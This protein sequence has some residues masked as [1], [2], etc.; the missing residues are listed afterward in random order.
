MRSR[1]IAGVNGGNRLA[2]ECQRQAFGL[3]TAGVVE[4]DVQVPLNAGVHIPHRLAMADRQNAG[5]LRAAQRG[6]SMFTRRG[7]AGGTGKPCRAAASMAGKT[8]R[9]SAQM[10]SCV[11]RV[12]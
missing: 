4:P 1:Q 11:A 6:I 8:A 7:P 5:G 12:S 10:P 9:A 3:P 2:A